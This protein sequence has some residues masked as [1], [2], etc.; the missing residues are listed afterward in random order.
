MGKTCRNNVI[1]DV[2]YEVYEL[3]D[4]D[5]SKADA[6]ILDKIYDG[7]DFVLPLSKFVDLVE[8]LW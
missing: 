7:M 8:T 4:S 5:F 1:E 6:I 3:T 2:E